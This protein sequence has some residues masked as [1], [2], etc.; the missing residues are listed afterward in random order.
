M[1]GLKDANVNDAL[2]GHIET[3]ANALCGKDATGATGDKLRQSLARI[4]GYFEATAPADI[5]LTLSTSVSDAAH[6]DRQFNTDMITS[7]VESDGVIT[8]TLN[9][10][11]SSMKDFDGGGSWGVH[12]WA[13]IGIKVNSVTD[14]TK[15]KFGG[16]SLTADD[17]TERAAVGLD[18]G[19][20]V[21]WFKAERVL[22]GLSNKITLWTEGCKNR[23]FTLKIVEG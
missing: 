8:I 18:S 15:L 12:K 17:E 20:F 23:T 4:A 21:L 3:I 5:N 7:A 6:A 9:G 22:A 14:L 13:G 10:K 19:Y 16:E 2:I 11:V 1:S